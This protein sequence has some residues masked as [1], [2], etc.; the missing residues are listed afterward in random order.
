MTYC[1][2]ERGRSAILGPDSTADGESGGKGG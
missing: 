1:V 2:A